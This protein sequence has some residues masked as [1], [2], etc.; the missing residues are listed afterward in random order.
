MPRKAGLRESGGCGSIPPVFTLRHMDADL[1]R[2]DWLPDRGGRQEVRIDRVFPA[3]ARFLPLDLRP[4]PTD[5][6]LGRWLR[7]RTIPANRA[8]VRNFLARLG[9]D[10]RDTRGILEICRGLSLQDV[11]WIAEDGFRKRWEEVNLYRN[12]FSGVLARLA[13]TGYGSYVRTTFQTSPEFTTNGA[14]PKCWRRAGGGVFL[15]KGGSEG[16]AN[17]GREPQSEFHAAQVAEALGVP[18]VAYGLSRFRGRLC[19][20]CPLFTSEKASFVPLSRLT[21]AKTLDEAEEFLRSFA[22]EFLP[23][24]RETVVFDAVVR[25]EDRHLGNLGVL[26]RNETN[27][28]FALAPAFDHGLSLFPFAMDEDL[29]NLDR[30]AAA[31]RPVLCP[32]FDAA[33]A[34]RLTRALRARLRRVAASFRFT[35]HPRHDLPAARLRVLESFVRAKAAELSRM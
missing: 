27:E 5:E 13:F 35:R 9:L 17:A 2:F 15:F 22:P 30:Y 4:S 32:D 16:A 34:A 31:R 19:S 7:G 33:A 12:R 23:A 6:A 29:A 25:N 8:Y 10:E 24:L 26:V 14:L 3:A 11:H 28:P 21:R 18:H 20:T 1:L